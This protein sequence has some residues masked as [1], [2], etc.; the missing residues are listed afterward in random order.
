[1]SHLFRRHDME[2][3]DAEHVDIHGGSLIYFVGHKGA[4]PVSERVTGLRAEEEREGVEPQGHIRAIRGG[5]GEDPG[6]IFFRSSG[7]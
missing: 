4:H 1:M 3:F 5:H 6:R 7:N 2:I